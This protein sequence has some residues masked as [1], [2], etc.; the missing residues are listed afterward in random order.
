MMTW[1]RPMF[2]LFMAAFPLFP[3]GLPSLPAQENA[4]APAEELEAVL[5][6]RTQRGGI[7]SNAV[8]L[9]G[10]TAGSLNFRMRGQETGSSVSLG[11]VQELVIH[12]PPSFEQMD[13]ALAE[14]N[15]DAAAE[16]LAQTV[17]ILVPYTG[18]R[19]SNAGELIGRAVQI[20][21]AREKSQAAIKGLEIAGYD[22]E[23]AKPGTDFA[24]MQALLHAATDNLE[25][26]ARL[27]GEDDPENEGAPETGESPETPAEGEQTA[28]AEGEPSIA[29]V[30]LRELL[31]VARGRLL[32]ARDEPDEALDH[33]ARVQVLSIPS[34]PWYAPAMFYS[35]LCYSDLPPVAPAEDATQPKPAQQVLQQMQRLFPE[36]AWTARL[37]REME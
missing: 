8:T 13:E 22:E 18:V 20:F 37:A 35:G 28:D 29:G 6:V 32:L 36:S 7:R 12:Q 5:R 24:L 33:F 19:G 1:I 34:N 10:R 9:T 14:D 25:G 27:I 17:N 16:T 3:A 23:S 2:I 15:D 4:N 26:A 21:L 11:V 31:E 30:P